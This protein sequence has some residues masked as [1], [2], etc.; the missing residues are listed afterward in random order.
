MKLA[1][2]ARPGDFVEFVD[3][4]TGRILSGRVEKVVR[5][6]SGYVAAHVRDSRGRLH[7]SVAVKRDIVAVLPHYASAPV[8]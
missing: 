5:Y 8:A 1:R 6:R 2:S 7:T 4:R 3:R